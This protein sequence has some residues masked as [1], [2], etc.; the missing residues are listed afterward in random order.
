M[1][2]H[3]V[4]D[5]SIQDELRPGS[6]PRGVYAIARGDDQV[7][8]FCFPA[9]FGFGSLRVR[10]GL[11]CGIH[12]SSARAALLRQPFSESRYGHAGAKRNPELDQWKRHELHG[13]RRLVGRLAACRVNERDSPGSN[14]PDLLGNL[15]WN[16]RPDF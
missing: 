14:R 6:C 4:V 15:H 5:F 16:G 2:I 9:L 12:P 1:C 10:L 8:F 7:S 11:E 13:K 3:S